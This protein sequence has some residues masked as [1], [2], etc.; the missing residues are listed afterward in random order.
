MFSLPPGE[1]RRLAMIRNRERSDIAAGRA[2]GFH[3]SQP[4]KVLRDLGEPTV[5]PRPGPAPTPT[6]TPPP[7]PTVAPA[8]APARQGTAR[9]TLRIN[10]HDYGC[11]Q[12]PSQTPGARVWGLRVLEGDRAG[13]HYTITKVR[14]IVACT[15]EDHLRR[16]TKCKH[17]AAITA[18]GLIGRTRCALAKKGGTL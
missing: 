14:G 4:A 3:Q 13:M 16:G 1:G 8:V 17:I 7:T 10:G 9:L 12:L 18:V 15:C 2:T 11:R 5:T 6:P